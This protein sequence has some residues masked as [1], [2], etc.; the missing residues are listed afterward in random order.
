[1]GWLA[2]STGSGSGPS[3]TDVAFGTTGEVSLPT[4]ASGRPLDENH[5]LECAP[6]EVYKSLMTTMH[7]RTAYASSFARSHK[8]SFQHRVCLVDFDSRKRVKSGQCGQILL[9]EQDI[10]S[11]TAHHAK[12]HFRDLGPEEVEAFPSSPPGHPWIVGSLHGSAFTLRFNR[13]RSSGG[14]RSG[15]NDLHCVGLVSGSACIGSVSEGHRHSPV[16]ITSGVG[17]VRPRRIDQILEQL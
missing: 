6:F 8:I 1:M 14:F 13:W 5:K 9:P 11:F 7:D 15:E 10:F 4:K 3:G 17:F 16:A 12:R 2:R